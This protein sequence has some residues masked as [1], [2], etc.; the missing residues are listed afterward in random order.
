[1]AINKQ[2]TAQSGYTDGENLT[3]KRALV[4]KG[5]EQ[6]YSNS[7]SR[8]DMKATENCVASQSVEGEGSQIAMLLIQEG[9]QV[10]QIVVT[11]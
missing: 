1:M 4:N 10:K 7:V 11:H 2:T 3:S 5:L 8:F 6:R 9:Q